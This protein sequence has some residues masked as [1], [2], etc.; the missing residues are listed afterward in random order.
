MPPIRFTL[1][2]E[3]FELAVAIETSLPGYGPGDA[4]A[5]VKVGVGDFF[6]GVETWVESGVLSTFCSGLVALEQTLTGEAHLVSITPGALSIRIF[7]TEYPGNVELSG[8]VGYYI[9]RENEKVWHSVDFGFRFA[10]SQL[11][12]AARLPWVMHYAQAR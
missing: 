1:H 2:D 8:R 11:S 10:S 9:H 6:G 12:K 5:I 4:Y 7:P 3:F